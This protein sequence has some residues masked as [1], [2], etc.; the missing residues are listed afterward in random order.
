MAGHAI[1]SCGLIICEPTRLLDCIHCKACWRVSALIALPHSN[2]GGFDMAA[3]AIRI[4]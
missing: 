3:K 2:V 1:F 4:E